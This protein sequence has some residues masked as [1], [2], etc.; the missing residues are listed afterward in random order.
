MTTTRNTDGTVTYTVTQPTPL[1]I[2][3]C[4]NLEQLADRHYSGPGA[5]ALVPELRKEAAARIALADLVETRQARLEKN[6][7]YA[8][9]AKLYA[10]DV[11]DVPGADTWSGLTADDC[12]PYL[13][14]A[15]ALRSLGV[16]AV[17]A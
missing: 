3:D 7:R 5:I 10:V 9:A 12:A 2:D 17:I 16:V 1:T 4:K 11:A 13:A 8:L 15:G 6:E 14:K